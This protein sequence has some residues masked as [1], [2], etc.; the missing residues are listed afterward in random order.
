MATHTHEAVAGRMHMTLFFSR[1]NRG[2]LPAQASLQ[3]PPRLLTPASQS[4]QAKGGWRARS[5]S[6]LLP[7]SILP[8]Y[9]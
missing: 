2:P 1:H 4:R 8:S 5:L 7:A 6:G 3:G 9:A